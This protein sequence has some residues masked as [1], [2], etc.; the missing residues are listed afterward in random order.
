[1]KNRVT[2][3]TGTLV[4]S[5][6][7]CHDEASCV[8]SQERG[9]S[10]VKHQ[11]SCVCKDG[12]VGDGLTC[13]DPKVC[14]DSSCCSQGYHWSAEIGCV[15]TDE[16]SLPESPCPDTQDCQNTPGSFECIEPSS[17]ARSAPSSESVQ[18]DCG[19]VLCP[20]GTD[21]VTGS[22]GIMHCVD[23]C[24]SY[25]VIDDDW[26]ATNHTT[27]GNA[28]SDT[29]N[30]FEGWYRF[31]LWHTSAQ[32]P[33]RCVGLNR[34]GTYSPMWLGSPHPTQSGIIVSRQM[35]VHRTECCSYKVHN[36][37]VKRCPGKYFVYK[38]HNHLYTRSAFCA[39]IVAFKILSHY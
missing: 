3:F 37:Y 14:S 10:F 28:I 38:L 24:E 16:C 36:I 2:L 1:M 29:T 34:C 27:T 26:R 12:F 35:C 15:D 4:T 22:D 39:G 33:E 23:P 18:F 20:V 19:H 21:C 31:F 8:E 13:Y 7:F 25:S 32:I 30:H 11:V 5:C 6:D 9:D 17:S